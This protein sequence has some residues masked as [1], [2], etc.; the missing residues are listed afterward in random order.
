MRHQPGSPP[1][2][3]WP[4]HR[5]RHRKRRS[6]SRNGVCQPRSVPIRFAFD[7]AFQIHSNFKV[8][9]EACRLQ[10]AI[11]GVPPCKRS[12]SDLISGNVDRFQIV[13]ARAPIFEQPNRLPLRVS[14][15]AAT[16]GGGNRVASSVDFSRSFWLSRAWPSLSSRLMSSSSAGDIRPKYC[17][18]PG[19]PRTKP[20]RAG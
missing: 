17:S 11:R 14:G 20:L 1:S 9:P 12:S 7:S 2:R 3:P 10:A 16:T 13:G 15:E 18:P 8:M 6:T 5:W 4:A 19:A